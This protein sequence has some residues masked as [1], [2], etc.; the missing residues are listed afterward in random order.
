MIRPRYR[1]VGNEYPDLAHLLPEGHF[2]YI[3]D[4]PVLFFMHTVREEGNNKILS[5]VPISPDSTP[6]GGFSEVMPVTEEFI[7]IS[8]APAGSIMKSLYI[9]GPI[10]NAR[11]NLGYVYKGQ[12]E[13]LWE[14]RACDTIDKIN[15]SLD[16]IWE[17]LEKY[18]DSS[19]PDVPG[20]LIKYVSDPNTPPRLRILVENHIIEHTRQNQ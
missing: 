20:E 10:I 14:D 8:E 19:A 4:D 5:I 2:V 9:A 15:E 13:I 7:K 16:P 6:D 12:S 1:N 17:S 11:F 18:L 3:E